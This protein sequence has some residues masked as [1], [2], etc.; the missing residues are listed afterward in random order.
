MT[1]RPTGLV[2]RHLARRAGHAPVVAL[3]LLVAAVA[4]ACGGGTE[5]ARSAA[6]ASGPSASS[7][8]TD[9]P[10]EF[11]VAIE[12][13]Y[14]TTEIAEEPERVLSLGYSDHDPILAL[15]VTPVAVRYW[16]GEEPF[17]VFAWARDELGEAQPELL[18]MPELDFE[19]IAGLRPDVIIGT[20]SGMSADDYDTLSAIAPTVAQSGDHV[21]YGMP[22]QDVTVTVGRALGR[23][24]RAEQ[25]VAEI[26]ERFETARAEHPE[27]EGA[28]VA[29]VTGAT[30]GE[31]GFFA[32]Q[33]PRARFFASLGF[34]TPDAFDEIAGDQF[35]G[36]VSAERLDLF[37]TDAVVWQ[38]LAFNDGGRAGIESDPFVQQLDAAGE[39]RMVFLEDELD[40]A[41]GFN[42]VLS[43][44]FVL[45]ELVPMLA[46]ALDGDPATAV[47]A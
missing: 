29:S 38:Q 41:F 20:Y 33:D 22:W 9:T 1:R 32:S 15:G 6:S 37:D 47:G 46:A 34:D 23:E 42:T 28:T 24:D 30:G 13:K 7:G 21:D 27:F 5:P 39:G 8:S 3:S 17:G 25:L 18:E 43:L 16:F 14:G 35:Y 11:P 31:Y 36:Y 45:D 12:H 44:P 10:A 4:G 2:R 19:K 40:D 26:E